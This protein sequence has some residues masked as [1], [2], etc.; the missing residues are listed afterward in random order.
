M[1]LWRLLFCWYEFCETIDQLFS[2]QQQLFCTKNLFFLNWLNAEETDRI[3][4]AMLSYGDPFRTSKHI[5]YK[6][7]I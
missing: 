3:L 6:F 2:S 7:K 4:M 5:Q 1:I